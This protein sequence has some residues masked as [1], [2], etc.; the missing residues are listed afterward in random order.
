MWPGADNPPKQ[1]VRQPLPTRVNYTRFIRPMRQA[2]SQTRWLHCL[3]P[4]CALLAGVAAVAEQSPSEPPI[5]L[6]RKTV[7]N[8]LH[9]RDANAKFMFRDHKE[10]PHGSQTKL[11]V[12]TSDAMAGILIAIDGKPLTPEQRE[13]ENARVDRFLKDPD[14]LKKRQKQEKDDAERTTRIMKA[15]PDAFLYEYDGTETG[16]QGLG[17]PGDPLVRLKFR[18]NPD[19]DP[20]SRVEQVLTGM[21]GYV[22]ID[23]NEDRIA[24]IDGTLEKS[25]GFGWGIL[26]HLDPGGHFLVQQGD[27]GDGHWEI[28]C[29]DLAFTGKILFFKSINI[30]STEME[31]DFRPVPSDLNF[32]Q[33][34]ALLRKQEGLLAE[35]GSEHAKQPEK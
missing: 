11:M 12:E 28:S 20:P 9:P 35:N 26:G 1:K 14:E 21:Q 22:L 4:A 15:L 31:S 30:K 29:M 32:A 33:G 5:D 13:A 24:K 19:Y 17:K 10:T 25:V 3:L 27:V 2:R 16:R 7:Y 6:V 18:P 23:T 34:L 8:E